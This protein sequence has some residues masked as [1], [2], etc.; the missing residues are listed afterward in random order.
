VLTSDGILLI[1]VKPEILISYSHRFVMLQS[2][3]RLPEQ[4]LQMFCR[5]CCC[6]L[7]RFL[8]ARLLPQTTEIRMLWGWHGL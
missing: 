2:T 3:K 4:M 8:S 1:T 5:L 7:T 6:Y